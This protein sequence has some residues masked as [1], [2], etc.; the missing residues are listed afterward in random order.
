MLQFTYLAL[1]LHN[2]P[3]TGLQLSFKLSYVRSCLVKLFCPTVCFAHCC[4]KPLLE[5]L[6]LLIGFGCITRNAVKPNLVFLRFPLESA[7]QLLEL[8]PMLSPHPV[9]LY[10]S[11]LKLLLDRSL[12]SQLIGPR[13]RA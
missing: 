7:S 5:A 9:T 10:L 11:S 8:L 3:F 4:S 12:S 6:V 13:W 2:L 1:T